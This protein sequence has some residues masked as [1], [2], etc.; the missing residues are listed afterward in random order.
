MSLK[1]DNCIDE[2]YPQNCRN[3]MDLSCL[4]A[5]VSIKGCKYEGKHQ[6]TFALVMDGP[7]WQGGKILS[8]GKLKGIS[9]LTAHIHD[10]IS[11]CDRILMLKCDKSKNVITVYL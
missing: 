2:D 6:V 1:I 8:V 7:V 3:Y 4:F 9:S 10:V 5:I 11:G